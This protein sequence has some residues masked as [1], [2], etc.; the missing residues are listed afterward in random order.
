MRIAS[1]GAPALPTTPHPVEL[2]KRP[3]RAARNLFRGHYY[4]MRS[5]VQIRRYLQTHAQRKL[6]LGCGA[7]TLKGWLNSDLQ[8]GRETVYL[9][10]NKALPLPPDSFAFIFHEHFLEHFSYADGKRIL[11]ECYR[12][13]Q[14]GGIL[15]VV[16]PD[17][18]FLIRL[19]EQRSGIEQRY[20][21]ANAPAGM[22][23]DLAATWVINQFVRE[24]GHLFIYDRV[25]LVTTLQELGFVDISVQQCGESPYPELRD[26]D[27]HGRL[28]GAEFNRLESLVVEGAKP[29]VTGN[30][31]A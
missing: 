16:T 4:R 11:S 29:K 15:R 10:A 7:N 3:L 31:L 1:E 25:T 2:G 19:H 28:I 26:I 14:P 30:G 18:G 9:N 5:P 12:L 17:L 6:Q 13:L 8:P 27:G 24:W 21:A 22:R 20:L 23:E